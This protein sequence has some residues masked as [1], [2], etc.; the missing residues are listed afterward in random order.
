[1]K[2]GRCTCLLGGYPALL[3]LPD[4]HLP[5]AL[6]AMIDKSTERPAK[7]LE[8]DGRFYLGDESA[9]SICRICGYRLQDHERIGEVWRC[10]LVVERKSHMP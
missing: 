3:L 4:R 9:I 6:R 2:A 5:H 1:M 8:H 7:E 10:P